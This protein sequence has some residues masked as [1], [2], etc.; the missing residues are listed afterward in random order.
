MNRS[1][2]TIL[3]LAAVLALAAC[4]S[5]TP[6]STP[7]VAPATATPS[8][9]PSPAAPVYD[10][11]QACTAFTDATTTGIPASADVPAGTTTMQ[12]LATQEGDAQPWLKVYI[13]E[14]T[15]AWAVTPPDTAMINKLTRKIDRICAGA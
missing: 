12:W 14:F 8:A 1:L 13:S 5:S 11:T 4:S 6:V 15:L 10:N 9:P 7:S 2:V 3:P